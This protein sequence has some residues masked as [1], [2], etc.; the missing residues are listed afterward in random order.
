MTTYAG[1][2][3]GW[4]TQTFTPLPEWEHLDPADLF[5]R[6]LF[7]EW[8]KI[9]GF[10]PRPAYG[11]KYRDGAFTPPNGF[12]DVAALRAMLARLNPASR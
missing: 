6:D 4:V 9:D 3:E 5:A 7:D 8:V 12:E 11:W 2:R 1:I 10:D